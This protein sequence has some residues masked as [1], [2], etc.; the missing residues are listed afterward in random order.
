MRSQQGKSEQKGKKRRSF[1]VGALLS[2]LL[3]A[4]VLT[5]GASFSMY[6]TSSS[7]SDGARVARFQVEFSDAYA[8]STNGVTLDASSYDTLEG[9]E[10]DTYPFGII[11]DSEVTVEYDIQLVFNTAPPAGLSFTVGDKTHEAD[12]EQTVFDF[13]GGTISPNDATERPYTL[14]ITGDLSEL[15]VNFTD[16]VTVK[17]LAQQLD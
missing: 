8:S 9:T 7:G 14:T 17:V 13:P 4:L 6:A 2:Y 12:G 10:T 5:T 3:L 1:A 15:D 16:L 11:C